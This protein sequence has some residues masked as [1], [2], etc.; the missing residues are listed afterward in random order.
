MWVLCPWFYVMNAF[1]ILAL[2]VGMYD[3]FEG[4]T[5]WPWKERWGLFRQTVIVS[6]CSSDDWFGNAP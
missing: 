3:S 4:W 6:A 1:L 2:G 5:V